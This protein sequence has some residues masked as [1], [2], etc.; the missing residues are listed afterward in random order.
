MIWNKN[1]FV[2]GIYDK[3]KNEKGGKNAHP[4]V[5]DGWAASCP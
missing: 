5:K 3:K 4:S 1:L 2:E